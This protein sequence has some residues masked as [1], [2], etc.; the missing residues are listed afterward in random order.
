MN[1]EFCLDIA[2]SVQATILVDLDNAVKHQ[3][4]SGR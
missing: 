3:H 2:F 4:I 1:I